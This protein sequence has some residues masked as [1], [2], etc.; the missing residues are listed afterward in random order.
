MA[1]NIQVNVESNPNNPPRFKDLDQICEIS[2]GP[3]DFSSTRKPPIDPSLVSS[4]SGLTN[5]SQFF[6]PISLNFDSGFDLSPYIVTPNH[7]QYFAA[8]IGYR[9]RITRNIWN[10]PIDGTTTRYYYIVQRTSKQLF[11]GRKNINDSFYSIYKTIEKESFP[12]NYIPHI[13]LFELVGGGG[14]GGGGGVFGTYGGA[15]GGA[16]I[17]YGWVPVRTVSS[18]SNVATSNDLIFSIYKGG[19]GGTWE[20]PTNGENGNPSTVV[21]NGSTL[22]EAGGGIRGIRG[23]FGKGQVGRGGVATIHNSTY[24]LT[25]LSGQSGSN[26]DYIPLVFNKTILLESVQWTSVSGY[27]SA[28]RGAGGAS[29]GNGADL[30]RSCNTEGGGG[31][32]GQAGIGTASNGGRGGHG[33]LRFF[34]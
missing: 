31:G 12:Q 7:N 8:K 18:F 28:T 34:Y 14:G 13:L 27:S 29:R 24:Y 11:I 33:F 1:T 22:M 9:P 3:D 6:P 30:T 5:V 21:K 2:R 17:I 32:G 15:G 4:S 20:G 23:A 26:G 25:S 16:S 10:Q 19:S